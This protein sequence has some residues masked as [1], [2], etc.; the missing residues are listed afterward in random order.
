MTVAESPNSMDGKNEEDKNLADKV[1]I[2][3]KMARAVI[4]TYPKLR[5]KPITLK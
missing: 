5:N 4:G 1:V 2:Q 3:G